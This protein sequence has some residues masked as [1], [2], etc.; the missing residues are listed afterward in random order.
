MKPALVGLIAIVVILLVIIGVSQT[1]SVSG[2]ADVGKTN[3]RGTFT[4]YYADWCPHCQTA[5]PLFK[6]FMGS[7]IKNING[8]QIKI[9]MIEEKD[10]KKSPNH[11][12]IKG[13]PSFL[14]SDASGKTMEYNGPRTAAG[15]MQFLKNDVLT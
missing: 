2:F 6:E 12:E 4:M 3:E 13:Y 1:G 11:P 5:K 9:D 14:F 8:Q 15:F 10:L 7:G